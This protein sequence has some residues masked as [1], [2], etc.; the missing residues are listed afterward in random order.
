M[1]GN[2]TKIAK[3]RKRKIMKKNCKNQEQK[4]KEKKKEFRREQTEKKKIKRNTETEKKIND[5]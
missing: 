5:A 4:W 3:E 2:N 1:E